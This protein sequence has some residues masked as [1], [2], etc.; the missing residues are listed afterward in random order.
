MYYI[1]SA[2]IICIDV[3]ERLA[4]SESGPLLECPLCGNKMDLM[5]AH[6]GVHIL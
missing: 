3:S 5:H 1:G 2:A 6:V 4:A